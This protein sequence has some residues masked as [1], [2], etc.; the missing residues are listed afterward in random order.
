MRHME[1]ADYAEMAY[2]AHNDECL[3][4]EDNDDAIDCPLCGE[5]V[6][7]EYV[8]GIRHYQCRNCGFTSYPHEL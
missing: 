2:W 4:E 3:R 6:E 7:A 8:N 1:F 5:R